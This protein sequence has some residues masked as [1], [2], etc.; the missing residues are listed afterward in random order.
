[1]IISCVRLIGLEFSPECFHCQQLILLD[2]LSA[3]TEA[4]LPRRSTWLIPRLKPIV[5]IKWIKQKPTVSY[6]A[7]NRGD[8]RI[9]LPSAIELFE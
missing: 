5:P 3:K 2:T 6:F 9:P 4:L 8:G 1:M 7:R